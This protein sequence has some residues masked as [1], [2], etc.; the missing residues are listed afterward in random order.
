MKWACDS[1]ALLVEDH[2][3][4]RKLLKRQL[5]MLGVKVDAVPDA[6]S[7]LQRMERV[8]YRLVL[9]DLGLP[10]MGG[11]ELLRRLHE[12]FR[13]QVS[14]PAL[15]AVTGESDPETLASLRAAGVDD[16]LV[17][18]VSVERLKALLEDWI[19]GSNPEPA[20]P[21]SCP[22]PDDGSPD[23]DPAVLRGLLGEDGAEDARR[24]IHLF[25]ESARA[26]MAEAARAIEARDARP[27]KRY[28]HRQWSAAGAVGAARFAT[29]AGRMESA[30]A[31]EDWETVGE[32]WPQLEATVSGIETY[33]AADLESF[34]QQADG[35]SHK[36]TRRS[37]GRHRRQVEQSR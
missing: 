2:P 17:K 26:G 10:G 36:P 3:V 1:R 5:G 6:E 24:L 14:A 9:T 19:D 11:E 13:G 34:R 25:V 32:C 35:R 4:N 23:L 37:G 28:L 30:V 12:R 21:A 27:L 7:A 15:I 20:S 29:L 18:P 22:D 31:A 16:V 33:L 8:S